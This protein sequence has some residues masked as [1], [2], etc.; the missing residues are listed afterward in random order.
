MGERSV[1][2]TPYVAQGGSFEDRM[3]DPATKSYLD[4]RKRN[5]T[6]VIAEGAS[7]RKEVK[8]VSKA[9]GPCCVCRQIIPAG[10]GK[11]GWQALR[12]FA[13]T[14]KAPRARMSSSGSTP[15][16][17]QTKTPSRRIWLYSFS[18]VTRRP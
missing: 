13:L 2:I 12:R 7:E 1:T 10:S 15:R 6:K 5:R 8:K 9:D 16:A 3:L 14:V 11:S 17:A 18:L 4:W